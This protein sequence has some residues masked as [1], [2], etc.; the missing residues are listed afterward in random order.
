MEVRSAAFATVIFAA[1]FSAAAPAA[2][3]GARHH[4]HH[5]HYRAAPE[6]YQKTGLEAKIQFCTECHGKV[7]HGFRGYYAIPQLAGQQVQYL[8]T[9]LTSMSD[10]VRN[11]PVAK[12]FM[13]P[14]VSSV[15]KDMFPVIAKRL[16]ELDAARATDGPR[17]LVEAGRKIYEDGIPD[18]NV[19]AC[20]ACHGPD[21]H[22]Q[23]QIPRLAGQLY[24]YLQD[25]LTAWQ[26]GFRGKDPTDPNNDNVM[27]PIASALNKEQI[28]EVAAYLSYQK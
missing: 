14:V 12:R 28:K 9:Q 10:H 7:F 4:R 5:R 27:V 23:D 26:H 3:I 20:S 16:S 1:V 11:D 8:E 13:W 19:P 25:Q 21:A 15:P 18:A 17:R 24:P 6:A 2:D 22:G